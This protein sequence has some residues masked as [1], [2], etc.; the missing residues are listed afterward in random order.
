MSEKND[1]MNASE[2]FALLSE[3]RKKIRATLKY[4]LTFNYSKNNNNNENIVS[5]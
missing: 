4:F 5:V 3:K 2:S 1:F